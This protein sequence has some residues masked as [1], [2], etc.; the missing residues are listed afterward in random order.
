MRLGLIGAGGMA[1]VYADRIGGIDG[2]TVGAVASPNTAA[3]FVAE[4]VPGAT[5][6]GDAEAMCAGADLDAAA[7][8]TPTHTHPEMV[9][10]AASHGLDVICEKPLARTMAGGRAIADAVADAG[11]T[12][13][14]AHVVRFFPEYAAAKERI[15]AGEVGD[16][17][18]ARTRRAFGFEGG[19]GWFDDP[20]RSG[21]VLLDLGV[22]DID[23]LRWVLGDV[24]R[25]FTRRAGWSG[26]GESEVALS[27]LRFGSG[28]V[29]H[30]EAWWVEGPA[31][32]FTTALEV[33]GDEGLIEHANDEVQPLRRFDADG[34]H[35]PRDPVG[36]DLPLRRDGYRRQL[37]HFLECA[38][39][40]TEPAV[41]V[42]EGLRSM[43]VALAAIES[44]ER[45]A[46]VAPA[47]VGQ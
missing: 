3:S 27:L 34:V 9:E 29:G 7:V 19:R 14:T 28:A 35:V 18:V 43:Q 15:D 26:D 1:G 6:Y 11:I 31:V 47:E 36:D 22:H 10:T 30:V 2:A 12:F 13:M 21:G 17:G 39:D 38:E 23:Y 32:P 25:V 24:E 4:R 33:A 8:V 16:P 45:G 42:G 44:A 5:A 46:P 37:E 40:G 20:E 41:P